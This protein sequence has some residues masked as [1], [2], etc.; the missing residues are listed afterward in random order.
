MDSSQSAL[1]NHGN[2]AWRLASRECRTEFQAV[3]QSHL[4]SPV[5]RQCQLQNQDLTNKH[6]ILKSLINRRPK[7]DNLTFRLTTANL[8]QIITLVVI[9]SVTTRRDAG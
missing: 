7:A 4:R 9:V 5:R 1:I 6:A 3:G 8:R 2:P